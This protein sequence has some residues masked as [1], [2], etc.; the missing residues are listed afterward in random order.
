MSDA[1][2]TAMAV[3]VAPTRT[4]SNR[5]PL[6]ALSEVP[7][8]A[9]QALAD[10][11][12]EPS[13]F[14]QP[15]YALNGILVH[16]AKSARALVAFDANKRGRM[17]GLLPLVSAW[18]AL[19]LPIPAMVSR[20]PYAPLSAPLLDKTAAVAAAGA[21]IDGAASNGIHLLVLPDM[22]LRGPAA[23][24][25]GEA[26]AERRLR[27]FIDAPF[28]RAAFNATTANVE[29]Y[30]R[31]G[32]GA[33]R[34]KEVRRL[35]N[36]LSEEGE[37]AMIFAREPAEIAMALERFLELE[38]RGW[39]GAMGTGLA[40]A[41][42]DAA[43]IRAAAADLGAQRRFEIAELTLDGRTIAA[44]L[45]VLQ[46]DRAFFL[47]IAYDETLGR[48]S[49][50]VQL[51]LELTRYFAERADVS[52]IDS[53]ARAGHPMIDHI[54]TER[55]SIGDMIIPTHR[56]LVPLALG[57]LVMARR[58]LRDRAKRLAHALKT[59]TKSEKTS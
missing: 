14:Y 19:R 5:A 32:M 11:G 30:L 23:Q 39:K 3:A 17:I 27:W 24:A 15:G 51:T 47:K 37:V 25:I 6:L 4:Q 28:E 10:L 43:F 49:P 12:I 7:R 33:K 26:L 50:G 8:A 58:A 45:V 54:W 48:V 55:L 21:L 13:G 29:D 59:Q 2:G 42:G 1:L 16:D 22:T 46:Q 20:L 41:Q 36:R 9:W 35:R 34:L 57:R 38:A 53:T 18:Q 52:L 40:Q 44:G 31:A 56:G